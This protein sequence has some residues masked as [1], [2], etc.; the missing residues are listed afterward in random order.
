LVAL[1]FV[2][3]AMEEELLCTKRF[4]EK[5]GTCAFCQL[6]DHERQQR[7]RIVAEEGPFVAF[8]A[9]AGRQPFET[10]I[11]PTEHAC[12]YQSLTDEHALALAVLLHQIVSRLQTQLTP[13]SYNLLL[14]TAPYGDSDAASYHWHLEIVPRSTQLAGLEWGTGVYINSL[15]PERAADLLR[16]AK[17]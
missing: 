11:L 7:L 10:W 16:E 8:C 14:H 17:V 13:L 2:P 1:P 5:R 3:P 4:Y 6:I 9:Y 15:A 12:S